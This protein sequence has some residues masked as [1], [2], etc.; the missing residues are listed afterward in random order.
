MR[1]KV[2]LGLGL[3]LLVVG[4]LKP[5][6]DFLKRSPQPNNGVE[7]YVMDAPSDAELLKEAQDITKI[8]LASSDSTRKFDSLKLASLY[9]DMSTLISI[10]NEDQVI[11]DT[12]A[13]RSAN[14]LAGKMLRLNIKDKYPDLA[15]EAKDL[16]VK[17][18]GDD[19]VVLDVELRQKAV[20]AFRALSWAC[21]EGSK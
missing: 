21:Y 10:D 19:D 16:V 14:S 18:I 6:L 12:A 7:C 2:L 20:A 4:I 3:L 9:C 15:T 13:I 17:A 5:N 8:L 1:N 11:K